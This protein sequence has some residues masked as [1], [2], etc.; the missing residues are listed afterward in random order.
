MKKNDREHLIVHKNCKD[1]KKRL[2]G[3]KDAF[4]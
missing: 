4:E 3:M 1:R 2:I